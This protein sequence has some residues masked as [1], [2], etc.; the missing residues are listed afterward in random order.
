MPRGVNT[1]EKVVEEVI[2]LYK[3]NTSISAISRQLQIGKATVSDIVNKYKANKPDEYEQARKE[4]KIEFIAG[5]TE[6]LRELLGIFIKRVH[7][8]A[9]SEESFTEVVKIITSDEDISDTDKK[10]LIKQ[11]KEV[12]CP[13]ITELSILFGTLY[14]KLERMKLEGDEQEG[15]GVVEL[16]AVRELTPPDDDEEV[17]DEQ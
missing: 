14:D 2:Y 6:L 3:V 15:S 12:M 4:K 5:T 8:I 7:N 10:K 9:Q 1:C 13:K 17:A 16:P 11:M